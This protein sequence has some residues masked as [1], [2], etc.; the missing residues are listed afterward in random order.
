MRIGTPVNFALVAFF[1]ALVAPRADQPFYQE[2][3]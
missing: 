3:P 2:L 1:V